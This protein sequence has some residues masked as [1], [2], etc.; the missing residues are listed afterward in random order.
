MTEERAL[1]TMEDRELALY[2]LET[3]FA[4]ATRQRAL[5]ETYIKGQLKPDKHF[6]T[7]SD[8]P[9]R[10]PSLTKEGAELICLPHALKAHYHWLFGPDKPPLDDAPYQITV[11]C[12][13]E[14]NG[15]FGGEGIGSAS[16]MITLKSGQRVQR[17]KD[18]G[19]RHNATVKMACKSSYIATCLN[20]TAASE[21]FTQDM[22]DDQAGTVSGNGKAEKPEHY[23]ELHQTPFF[24][25]GKMRSYAHP[26]K[27]EGGQETG[28]WCHEHSQKEPGPTAPVESQAVAKTPWAEPIN[29][30]QRDEMKDR[31]QRIWPDA[32]KMKSRMA[33]KLKQ[34]TPS[35]KS[36]NLTASQAIEVI[37][38]LAKQEQDQ[39]EGVG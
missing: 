5:L 21:F 1:A 38:W 29:K 13:M 6:Y 12:E 24:K 2:D 23:C 25:R 18:P 35:C 20:A 11:K 7:V 27:G 4:M 19:L 39:K 32:E 10:K 31:A 14:A 30:A 28:E 9:G 37:G 8:D 22:E 15:K 34:Y 36:E 16:S 33:L 26:K 17:Q 3:R